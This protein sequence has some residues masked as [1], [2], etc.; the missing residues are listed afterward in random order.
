MLLILLKLGT[1]C[2]GLTF[3]YLIVPILLKGGAGRKLI[4][5]DE[6]GDHLGD[7]IEEGEWEH[8]E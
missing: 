4:R 5:Y 7:H 2:A 3:L 6:L 8:G 1:V